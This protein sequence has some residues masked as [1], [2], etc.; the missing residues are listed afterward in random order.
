MSAAFKN[1]RVATKHADLALVAA[2]RQFL[3]G[4]TWSAVRRLVEN[5]HVQINGN[6]CLDEGRQAS[7]G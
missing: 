3:P 5:R 1:Y 7:A 6:L 2:L 4:E